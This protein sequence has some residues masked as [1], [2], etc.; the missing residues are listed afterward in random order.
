[1]RH[2]M[3]FR[4]GL[5]CHHLWVM[6]S[7]DRGWGRDNKDM[8]WWKSMTLVLSITFIFSISHKIKIKILVN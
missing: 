5:W 2:A 8:K 6:R 3:I 7:L 4:M 1:M